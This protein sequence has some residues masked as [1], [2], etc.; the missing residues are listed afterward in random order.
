MWHTPKTRGLW[1]QAGPTQLGRWTFLHS[2][3]LTSNLAE[4]GGFTRTMPSLPAPDLQW[5]VLPVPFQR[6]G[7]ADPSVRAISM[8]IT[9]VSVGSRGVV[10]LR[11]DDPR[12]KPAIDPGYLYASEDME[13]LLSGLRM[14]REFAAAGPLA[15][16]C[17]WRWP[18]VPRCGPTMSCATSSATIWARCTTRSG[19]ARWAATPAWRRAN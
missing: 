8:L 10:R 5:H 7:L 3:P 17:T 11:S 12:H 2:G 4:A 14:A 13:P 16:L 19:R 9:L 18:L 15:K 6:Q 1:E